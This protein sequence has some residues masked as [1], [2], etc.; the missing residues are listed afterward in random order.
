MRPGSLLVEVFNERSMGTSLSSGLGASCGL[1][2]RAYHPR[3]DHRHALT[4]QGHLG[5]Y[6]AGHGKP[7]LVVNTSVLVAF[8]AEWLEGTV[9]RSGD[10][11]DDAQLL[12]RLRDAAPDCE[13]G[14]SPRCLEAGRACACPS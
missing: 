12:G 2:H 6:I 3:R 1:A 5:A 9:L 8:I 14:G 11:V 13:A 10:L 7:P 4:K